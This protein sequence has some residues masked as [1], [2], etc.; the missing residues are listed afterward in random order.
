MFL[1]RKS[2]TPGNG[3]ST[4]VVGL[5]LV[6]WSLHNIT[7]NTNAKPACRV[8]C[9]YLQCMD[10]CLSIMRQNRTKSRYRKKLIELNSSCQPKSPSVCLITH[11]AGT[12]HV[13]N[14]CN[15]PSYFHMSYDYAQ[16]KGKN[17][18]KSK[19]I[20][21][22]KWTEWHLVKNQRCDCNLFQM[23]FSS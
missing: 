2:G 15:L 11:F 22:Y 7:W 10:Q 12:R 5:L 17:P 23:A 1:A 6:F 4:P 3:Q 19:Q 20:S 13:Y 18:G 8:C 14:L 16:V 9:L 21:V